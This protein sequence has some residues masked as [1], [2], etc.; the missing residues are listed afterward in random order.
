MELNFEGKRKYRLEGYARVYLIIDYYIFKKINHSNFF[1]NTI[2]I[3]L[4]CNNFQK[5][6]N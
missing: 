5:I 3:R 4:R 1:T 2:T 6:L